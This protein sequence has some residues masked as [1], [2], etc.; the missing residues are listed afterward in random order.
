VTIYFDCPETPEPIGGIKQIYRQVDVLNS[1]GIPAK[2]VHATEGFRCGWF[3]HQTSIG[4][5][6]DLA[7]TAKDYLVVPECRPPGEKA[8]S[9]SFPWLRRVV[10]NQNC[11]LTFKDADLREGLNGGYRSVYEDPKT[12]AVITVSRDSER[13]LRYLFPHL[14]IHTVRCGINPDVFRFAERK[15]RVVSFTVRKN[16][17]LREVLHGLRVRGSLDGYQVCPIDNMPQ[18]EVA[19]VMHRSLIFLT[20]LNYEGFG[21]PPAEAMASGCVVV[22][23]DGRGGREYFTSQTGFPVPIGDLGRFIEVV[24]TVLRMADDDMEALH[25]IRRRASSFI[26]SEYS[27]AQEADSVVAA[28]ERILAGPRERTATRGE[29]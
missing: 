13:V 5:A 23:F 4:Y 19:E 2:V 11:Y 18:H 17:V 10:F 1:R 3:S 25:T 6:A 21:L 7:P 15:E 20:A 8:L 22:G 27:L 24:E 28:W 14:D 12:V 9:D 26:T 16:K 29:R